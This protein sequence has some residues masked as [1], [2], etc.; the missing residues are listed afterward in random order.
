MEEISKIN[1]NVIN[2]D[3]IK[4][5]CDIKSNTKYKAYM[6]NSNWRKHIQGFL[7][8]C[9]LMIRGPNDLKTL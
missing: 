5:C 6:L 7:Q 9:G 2:L 1:M 8:R 3:E 4:S